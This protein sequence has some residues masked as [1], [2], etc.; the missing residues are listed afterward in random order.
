MVAEDGVLSVEES[1]E[2]INILVDFRT[3]AVDSLS[4]PLT[5]WRKYSNDVLKT[6]K[7]YTY[8]V[9]QEKRD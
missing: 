5:T 8:G 3:G 2:E 9:N 1:V 7:T 6:S 4:F